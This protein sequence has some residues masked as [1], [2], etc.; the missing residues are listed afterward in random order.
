MS[1][2]GRAPS[3]VAAATGGNTKGTRPFVPE[4]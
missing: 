4:A 1:G 2:Q 3:V